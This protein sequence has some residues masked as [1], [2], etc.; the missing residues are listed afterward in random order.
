MHCQATIQSGPNKHKICG[1]IASFKKDDIFYCRHHCKD[2]LL[3][4]VP[5]AAKTMIQKPMVQNP[6]FNTPSPQETQRKI[7]LLEKQM[8]DLILKIKQQD[9]LT[10]NLKTQLNLMVDVTNQQS[11]V[12]IDSEKKIKQ[13]H[14]WINGERPEDCV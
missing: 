10:N 4:N 7:S 6:I 8:T 12:I 13:L 3:I 14:D 2:G 11:V 5:A 1:N 9:E